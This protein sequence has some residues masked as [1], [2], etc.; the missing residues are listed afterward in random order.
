MRTAGEVI[1]LHIVDSGFTRERLNGNFGIL[2]VLRGG[3]AAEYGDARRRLA[4]EDF[5]FLPAG[6]QFRAEP[7]EHALVGI[8]ELDRSVLSRYLP[9]GGREIRCEPETLSGEIREELRDRLRLIFSCYPSQEGADGALLAARAF[10]LIHRLRTVCAVRDPE[11]GKEQRDDALE[12]LVS[13]YLHDHYREAV[14]LTSLAEQTFYSTSF[15]SRFIKRRFGKNFT[16]YLT[17]LRLEEAENR[18]R[19]GRTPFLRI[20]TDCGFPNVGAF[21]RAFRAAYGATPTEYRRRALEAEERFEQ[22][23]PELEQAI[24]EFLDQKR[25]EYAPTDETAVRLAADYGQSRALPRFWERM[26]NCGYARDLLNAGMQA[27]M[28]YLKQELD[29]THVRFW[30]IWSREMMLYDGN[31]ERR[32]NFSRLDTVMDFLHAGGMYPH[33]ELG[34][35]PVI[36][37][38]GADR[39]IF[40]QARDPVFQTPRDLGH[41]VRTMLE[42]Y[43]RRYDEQYLEH[44]VLELW[45]DHRQQKAAEEY[46]KTFD[47]L[48]LAAKSV[49]PTIRLGGAGTV[50]GPGPIGPSFD[51]FLKARSAAA[52]RPDFISLYLYPYDNGFLLLDS[53]RAEAETGPR[54]YAGTDYA[55]RYL[56]LARET[57]ERNGLGDT[58]LY[59]TEWNFTFSNRDCLNDSVFKGACMAKLLIDMMGKTELAGYMFGSDL[60]SEYYDSPDP[61]NGG[62]GLLTKDGIPKPAFYALLFF[63]RLH[64]RLLAVNEHAVVTANQRGG[65]SIVCHN[66]RHPNSRYYDGI[67]EGNL[68]WRPEEQS[69]FFL[70]RERRLEFVIE[71]MPDGIYYVKKRTVDALRGSIQD[72]WRRMGGTEAV[73]GHDMEYLSRICVPHLTVETAEAIRGRLV[74]RTSLPPHAIENLHIFP[75]K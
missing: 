9:L 58:L 2:F 42:H 59:V 54:P 71:G 24:S 44:W 72:E 7:E 50:R 20:A 75:K 13:R 69:S 35:R 34:F 62:C 19:T 40:Y 29:F 4:E 33:L 74:I 27:Q 51:A 68:G 56:T 55:S 73:L 28:L 18:V 10:E 45:Y 21:N 16:Q 12:E 5:L 1:R 65:L 17:D 60:F 67:R 15:L 22:P 52:R 48:S 11:R 30:D 64:D 26:I 49:I 47:A 23:G 39:N 43:V 8:A 37:T 38:G 31:P 3:A 41:F 57:M 53:T 70:E 63:H 6:E 32:Y 36:L 14:T 25:R 66:Y 46:W 61:L